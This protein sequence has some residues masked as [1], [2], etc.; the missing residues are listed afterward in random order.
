M[1]ARQIHTSRVGQGCMRLPCASTQDHMQLLP[2]IQAIHFFNCHTGAPLPEAIKVGGPYLCWA[3]LFL[4]LPPC[5]DS[6][7]GSPELTCLPG[8]PRPISTRAG[9]ALAGG[10][11][12][13]TLCRRERGHRSA[14][15]VSGQQVRLVVTLIVPKRTFQPSLWMQQQLAL[16]DL[17]RPWPTR[18][19]WRLAAAGAQGSQKTTRRCARC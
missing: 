12:C 15:C 5:R 13:R 1:H 6:P 17:P 14:R 9:H 3:G 7:A 10:G 8:T 19:Y 16:P 4:C 2:S 18:L 11:R